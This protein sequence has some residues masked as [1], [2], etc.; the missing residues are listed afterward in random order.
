MTLRQTQLDLSP[1]GIWC[2]QHNQHLRRMQNQLQKSGRLAPETWM[3]TTHGLIW[4]DVLKPGVANSL[5]TPEPD[6]VLRR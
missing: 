6:S 1:V 3:Q 2:L 5:S 4:L